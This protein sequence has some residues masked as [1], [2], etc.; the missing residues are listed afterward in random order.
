MLE[1]IRKFIK[2]MKHRA[3]RQWCYDMREAEGIAVFGNC[4][5]VVGGDRATGYLAY[6]CID[7]PYLVLVDDD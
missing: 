5:G 3:S 1:K 6:Q 4:C 7:C 2:H